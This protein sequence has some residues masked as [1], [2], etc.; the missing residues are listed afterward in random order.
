MITA[1]Y[2]RQPFPHQ[3][4]AIEQLK[5][6]DGRAMLCDE[7]GLGKSSTSLW[8]MAELNAD[9]IIIV[10]PLSVVGKWCDEVEQTVGPTWSNLSSMGKVKLKRSLE[11]NKGRPWMASHRVLHWDALVGLS[12][13]HIEML[14]G[15]GDGNVGVLFDES[16]YVRNRQ[17]L[18]SKAARALAAR[19]RYVLCLT[20]TPIRND[21]RDLWHQVQLARPG[22]LYDYARFET[23]FTRQFLFKLPSMKR[24]V[25][26]FEGT[27]NEGEL[28]TR[29][30][31]VMVMRKKSDVFDLPPKVRTVVPLEMGRVERARYDEMKQSAMVVLQNAQCAPIVTNPTFPEAQDRM[32]A[33]VIA[34][35]ALE[36]VIRLEQLTCG[37]LGGSSLDQPVAFHDAAKIEWTLETIGDLRAQGRSVVVFC[38]F[39][40]TIRLL[41]SKIADV[42]SGV[43]HGATRPELRPF[44]IATF[45]SRA[46]SNDAERAGVLL[47]QLKLAEGFDL[48]PCTDAIFL[49][50]DWTPAMMDQAE[51]RLH[52]IGTTGT[53]NCYYPIINRS[54]DKRLFNTVVEK[55]ENAQQVLGVGEVMEELR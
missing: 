6:W 55:R 3:R 53:V 44:E 42:P 23:R 52:R 31:D 29:L 45:R 8:T 54:I 49:G 25:R 47:C 13:D 35:T 19:A 38:K 26:K 22:H 28:A 5:M 7:M 48:T 46:A 9:R 37:V 30:H 11:N 17:A 43:I 32:N 18:R 4:R 21:V 12:E 16:H 41:V 50:I 40:A 24:P 15:P 10:C 51:D 27:K 1:T 33:V 34:R 2:L 36:Q 20:G 14:C 39:N